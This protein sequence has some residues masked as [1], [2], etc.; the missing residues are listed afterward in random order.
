MEWPE[1]AS[2]E[3]QDLLS[4]LDERVSTEGWVWGPFGL[5]RSYLDGAGDRQSRRD[6][7]LGEPPV[8]IFRSSFGCEVHLG[9]DQAPS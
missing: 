4:R 3:G 9:S 8:I 5:L 2:A 1:A 7:D 6:L